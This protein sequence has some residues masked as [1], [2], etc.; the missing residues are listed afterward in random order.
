MP[1]PASYN[2]ISTDSSIR[3]YVGWAWYRKVY[4]VPKRWSDDLKVFIRFGSVHY[5]AVVV[6]GNLLNLKL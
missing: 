3:D 1:V 6:S 4:Y 2:D 5:Y